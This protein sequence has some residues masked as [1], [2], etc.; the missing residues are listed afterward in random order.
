[1]LLLNI[2]SEFSRSPLLLACLIILF[3]YVSVFSRSPTKGKGASML[4]IAGLPRCGCKARYQIVAL[5]IF[6]Q[7]KR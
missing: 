1:M 3:V 7:I 4:L 5:Q 6:A 2:P